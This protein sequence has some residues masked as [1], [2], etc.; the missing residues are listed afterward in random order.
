MKNIGRGVEATSEEKKQRPDRPPAP[1]SHVGGVTEDLG[2]V[3]P[4]IDAN[5]VRLSGGP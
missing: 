4:E 5:L 1:V 2:G 3:D